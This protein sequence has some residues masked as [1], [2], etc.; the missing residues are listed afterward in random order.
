MLSKSAGFQV[1]LKSS[2]IWLNQQLVVRIW[3]RSSYTLNIHTCKAFHSGYFVKP[4]QFLFS[5][6]QILFP[7][8]YITLRV[9]YQ[10]DNLGQCDTQCDGEDVGVFPRR[11]YSFVVA[12]VEKSWTLHLHTLNLT[13]FLSERQNTKQYYNYYVYQTLLNWNVEG[14]SFLY[15]KKILYISAL[16]LFICIEWM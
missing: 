4:L 6:P 1:N 12:C 5:L 14:I 2:H 11:P 9:L 13:E 16:N 10:C 15:A 8:H 7:L 3:F